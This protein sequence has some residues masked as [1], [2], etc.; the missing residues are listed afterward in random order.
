MNKIVLFASGN[1]SNV[2]NIIQYF[3]N[4]SNI[5]VVAVFSNNE[6][7]KVLERAKHHG[8]S[9]E[10]FSKTELHD[11]AVL[12]KLAMMSPDLI[13]LAGFL[14]KFPETIINQFPNKVINIHPA[15]LPNYGGKGMYGKHVHQ[16]ILD[17]NEKQTGITIHYVNEHYDKGEF[18]LQKKVNIENCNTADEIAIKVLELEHKYFPETIGRILEVKTT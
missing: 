3:K 4:N 9:S 15:L 6:H 14:L 8:I 13:V 2:E 18:I 1:G 7:A 12:K 11:G 17:N 16:A 5:S 10:S